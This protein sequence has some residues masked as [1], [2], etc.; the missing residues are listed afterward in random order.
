MADLPK[1]PVLEKRTVRERFNDLLDHSWP[2]KRWLPNKT[3][4]PPAPRSSS[5]PIATRYSG[6]GRLVAHR[7]R[8]GLKLDDEFVAVAGR[9]VVPLA[10]TTGP[11]WR[12]NRIMHQTYVSIHHMMDR[13]LPQLLDYLEKRRVVYYAGYPSGLYL[14]AVWMRENNRRLPHPPRIT[15]TGAETLLPHQRRV[16][17]ETLQTEV[18]DQY[19]ASEGCGNISECERHVYHMDTEFGAIEL[20]PLDDGPSDLRRIIC[21]GF[22][23]PIMPLIR[24]NIGDVATI[25]SDTG[26][27]ECGRAAPTVA[28]VDGRIESYILTP[29]GRQLGR[30]DF[31]FKD[32]ANIEEA[33]LVQE[34]IE[35]VTVKLV[36]T[37]SYSTADEERLLHDMRSYLGDKIEIEIEYVEEIRAP[38]TASFD[39]LSRPSSRTGMRTSRRRPRQHACA[40]LAEVRR[41]GRMEHFGEIDSTAST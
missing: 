3:G 32:S 15:A 2:R 41:A 18:A 24:Y 25:S 23:N 37:P 36:R 38:P 39:R 19:G 5:S 21:T 17:E 29:D 14:L 28:R 16:I 40:G 26:A 6:S 1:L 7:Q 12:R 31:L 20:L 33:Q 13:T 30:L 4:A 22:R 10:Q 11:I 8:F 35:S 34:R 27:C 9:A